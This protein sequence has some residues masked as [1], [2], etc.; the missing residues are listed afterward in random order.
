MHMAEEVFPLRRAVGKLFT[1]ILFPF[2]MGI[3]ITQYD[4]SSRKKFTENISGV[5]DTGCGQIFFES[6]LCHTF[7]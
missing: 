3:L 4:L 2:L 7:S 1:E 6:F 5:Y